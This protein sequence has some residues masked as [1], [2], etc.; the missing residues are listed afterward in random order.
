ME[1]AVSPMISETESR[2][3][4]RVLLVDDDPT[5]RNLI[6]HF[7]RLEGILVEKAESGGGGLARVKS[8]RPDLV[9]I[10]AT[11]PGMDGGDLL[12]LLRKDPETIDLPVLMLSSL[13]EEDEIIRS[14]DQGA[15]YLIKPFSP[16]ILAAM[17]KKVLKEAGVYAVGRRPL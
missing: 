12:S 2:P 14:L 10:D 13:S 3:I 1:K 8:S 17:V 11:A 7:L 9:I 5:T 15:D 4:P 6:S 16:R